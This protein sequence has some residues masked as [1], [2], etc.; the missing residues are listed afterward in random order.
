MASTPS[1]ATCKRTDLLASRKASCVSRTSPGLSSTKRTSL[2]MSSYLRFWID[3]SLNRVFMRRQLGLRQPEII[4]AT[5]KGLEIGQLHWLAEIA[6][7]L[8][9]IAFQNVRLRSR[10]S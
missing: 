8:E 4:D 1:A 2:C 10:G 6:V 5:H 3:L 7:R 9:L